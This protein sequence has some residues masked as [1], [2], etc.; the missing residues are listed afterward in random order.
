MLRT[1]AKF[2]ILLIAIWSLGVV[3]VEIIGTTI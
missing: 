2:L 3:V 1:T